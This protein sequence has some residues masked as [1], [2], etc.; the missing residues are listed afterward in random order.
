MARAMVTK[1]GFSKDVGIVFHAGE[2]GEHA[3]EE[4]RVLIDKEVKRLCDESYTR[5]T[6]CL[7]KHSREHKRLAEALL[8]YETLTGKE[9]YDLVQKN[10][11]PKKKKE[12]NRGGA[13]G[14]ETI[15]GGKPA[16][17]LAKERARAA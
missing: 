1:Y 9:V 13:K 2:L 7:K 11:R 10:V 6:E 8:E 3:A 5:A 17:I 16:H 4:T 14:D 15:L 12:N